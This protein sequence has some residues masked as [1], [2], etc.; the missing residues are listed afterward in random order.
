MAEDFKDHQLAKWLNGE[1]SEEELREHFT[2]EDLLKFRQILDEVDRWTPDLETEVFSPEVVTRQEKQGKV[3]RL[4]LPLSVAASI[5]ILLAAGILFINKSDQVRYA[6]AAGETRDIALPDGRS[7]IILAANSSVSWTDKSWSAAQRQVNL[8]GKGFLQVEEGSPFIVN[9]SSGKVE[10]LGTSFEVHEFESGLQVNCYQGTVK[11]T[12]TGQS[13]MMVNA[14][15]S[16]LYFEGQ[17]EAKAEVSDAAPQW[18]NNESSFE[19]A[20]LRQ[21]IKTLESEYNLKTDAGTIN[22]SRRFTGSFPNNNLDEALRLVF[23][24]LS[25]TYELKGDRLYLSE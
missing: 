17:W 15:E 11:A 3:R 10:V 24:P 23:V 18:L 13:P 4:W 25:I 12:V 22:L 19:N 16:Y 8:K 2:P 7:T 6:T 9:T 14:G 21:V 20:P 1:L 5:L